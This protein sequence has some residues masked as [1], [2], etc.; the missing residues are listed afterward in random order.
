MVQKYI[1]HVQKRGRRRRWGWR[2]VRFPPGVHGMQRGKPPRSPGVITGPDRSRVSARALVQARTGRRPPI[3][4]SLRLPLLSLPPSLKANGKTTPGE[5]YRRA[6]SPGVFPTEALRHLPA[7]PGGFSVLYE[8]WG[9]DTAGDRCGDTPGFSSQ[10]EPPRSIAGAW[11]IPRPPAGRS[12]RGGATTD[13]AAAVPPERPPPL[14]RSTGLYFTETAPQRTFSERGGTLRAIL[15]S[16]SGPGS[17]VSSLQRGLGCC[18]RR[19]G[20]R[21]VWLRG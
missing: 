6:Q 19:E 5:D 20:P 12:T 8:A 14:P 9:S 7:R 21:P 13:R 11:R 16:A 2:E 10:E 15:G 1:S 4:V 18:E 17:R 3:D